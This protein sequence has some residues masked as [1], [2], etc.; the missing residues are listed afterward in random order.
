VTDPL[1]HQVRAAL[2]RRAGLVATRTMPVAVIMQ[3]ARR[4]SARRRSTGIA[5]VAVA[6]VAILVVGSLAG[7]RRA[8]PPVG[9]SHPAASPTPP[10]V[11]ARAAGITVISGNTIESPDGRRTVIRLPDGI[12]A[13]VAGRASGGWVALSGREVWW[14]PDAGPPRMVDQASAVPLRDWLIT[15]DGHTLVVLNY[16]ELTSYALPSLHVI[17]SVA[18]SSQRS[19][20]LVGVVGDALLVE[21]KASGPDDGSGLA[22]N[23]RT[24]R[25]T[26]ATVGP[27]A[28]LALAADGSVL[29]QTGSTHAGT[30]C[31]DVVPLDAAL[32][33]PPGRLC[34]PTAAAIGRG[35]ISPRGDWI[36]VHIA[37]GTGTPTRVALA[38]SADLDNGMWRPVLLPDGVLID[39]WVGPT[40]LVVFAGTE[41]HQ[42]LRCGVDGTC[43]PLIFPTD[44]PGAQPLVR[45]PQ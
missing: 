18:L 1:E 29:R 28:L 32:S 42:F 38:R 5:A 43:A 8:A 7:G 31:V 30:A 23:V 17:R 39:G 44:L 6:I 45:T 3:A 2:T 10:P 15:T 25:L 16:F 13:S 11:S 24:G 26:A 21:I 37:D 4:R 9:P 27:L 41:S 20:D 36:A 12:I 35:T 22:W 19:Y 34:G 14:V 40:E 33:A